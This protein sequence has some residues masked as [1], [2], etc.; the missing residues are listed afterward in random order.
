V[1]PRLAC[2]PFANHPRNQARNCPRALRFDSHVFPPNAVVFGGV[3]EPSRPS[4]EPSSVEHPLG[5]ASG[6]ERVSSRWDETR[7][8]LR[9]WT[10]AQAPSE[11]LADQLPLSEGYQALDPSHP[12]GGASAR[13][14][15]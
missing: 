10:N 15:R 4:S 2:R 11:R 1:C 13:S 7:H 3:S 14:E 12:L 6:G 9:A 8:R 5:V